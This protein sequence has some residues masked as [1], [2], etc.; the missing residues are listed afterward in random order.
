MGGAELYVASVTEMGASPAP[1]SRVTSGA[2]TGMVAVDLPAQR[3]T[4]VILRQPLATGAGQIGADEPGTHER[5]ADP[6]SVSR[7]IIGAC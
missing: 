2:P 5:C 1:W 6:V 4:R 3:A 7:A